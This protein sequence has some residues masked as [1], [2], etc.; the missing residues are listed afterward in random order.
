MNRI[1]ERVAIGATACLGG[2]T[3]GDGLEFVEKGDV[4]EIVEVQVVQVEFMEK[5][6]DHGAHR[7]ASGQLGYSAL[8]A[9][10]TRCWWEISQWKQH[11]NGKS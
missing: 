8:A 11:I 9:S 10:F 5:E 4:V 3:S 7:T 1:L 2:A 6:Q